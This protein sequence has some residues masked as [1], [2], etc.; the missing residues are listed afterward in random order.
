MEAIWQEKI[1]NYIEDHAPQAQRLLKE[2]A[3]IPAPSG[4][5]GRR[6]EYCRKWLEAQ[7]AQG[8]YV[9]E[10]GNVILDYGISIED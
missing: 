1:R 4:K 2:L 6:A 8:V 7:G 10:A 5:E 3:V 9:D